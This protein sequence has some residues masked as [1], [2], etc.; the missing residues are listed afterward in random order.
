[1]MPRVNFIFVVR[2]VAGFFTLLFLLCVFVLI[3]GLR[4]ENNQPPQTKL[5]AENVTQARKIL[6][7][8]TKIKPD[9]IAAI[10]FTEADLNLAGNYLLNRY[11]QSAIHIELINNKLRCSATFT[12]PANRFA[13]YFTV[14]FRLSSEMGKP[15]PRITKFKVGQLLLPAKLADWVIHAMIRHSFLNDYF[16]LATKPILRV[17]MDNKT[18]TIFY[19]STNQSAQINAESRQLYQQKIVE[20]LTQRDSKWRLSLAELLKAVFEL[21]YQRATLETAIQENRSAILAINDYVNGEDVPPMAAFLYKRS[22]LAQHF[23]GTAALTA[24]TNSQVAN[25]LGE[26]KE[27]SDTRA[28]GSGFSFVDL[29]ADKA[30]SR[31]GELA[32]SSPE[33]ARRLQ[34]LTAKINDYRDFMPDPRDLP[35]HMNE[36]DFKRLFESTQSPA[37]LTLATQIDTR[38]ASMPLY[39]LATRD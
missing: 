33:N 25:A 14:S 30:G 10:T 16:I 35:E 39:K 6:Y 23:I 3:S 2:I 8:G 24:S 11:R 32:V 9:D 34:A 20:V 15:L 21:A 29:A 38:I 7:E 36:A 19:D 28:G 22:D 31:F 12:L 27:L 37:Y 18:L 1:M 13:N 4:A 26:A 5:T 17:V